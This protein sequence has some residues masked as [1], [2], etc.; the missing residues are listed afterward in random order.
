MNYYY[1]LPKKNFFKRG[2]RGSV[3]HALGIVNGFKYNSK[4]LVVLHRGGFENFDDNHHE[5]LKFPN[6]LLFLFNILRNSSNRLL[7]RYS[8]S[9]LLFLCL[10]QLIA[11]KKNIICLE[12]NTV[13]SMYNK[14]SSLFIIIS[15]LE[16]LILRKFKVIYVVSKNAKYFLNEKLQV[17]LENIVI[18]PNALINKESENINDSSLKKKN[19]FETKRLVYLGSTHDYYDLNKV[20]NW[21]KEFN[22]K[23]ET[24]L[25]L[26]IY[27]NDDLNKMNQLKENQDT[28]LKFHG[29]YDN[30]K[31]SNLIKEN[32]L[33]ILPYKP[34]TIAEYGSPTKLFEYMNLKSPIFA[35]KV[36]QLSDILKHKENSILY[37][38]QD[39][40]NE[41]LQLLLNNHDL[42]KKI[43]QKAYQEVKSYHN[44]KVRIKDLIEF[45]NS[46]YE[47]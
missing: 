17:P 4:K 41:G 33:L 32:D 24:K 10:L 38:N 45:W 3:M 40:F 37:G 13:L 8:M 47:K 7:I 30:N 27:G 31:I 21:L 1:F 26:H 9:N 23:N 28:V 39:E 29:K 18:I 43:A 46:S 12:I 14:K 15:F 6:L 20:Y 42:R 16:K 2:Y 34:E 22:N 35:S 36:G 44:W 19:Y 25:E 11:I 5:N